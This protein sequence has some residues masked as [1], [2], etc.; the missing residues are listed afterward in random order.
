MLQTKEDF[1]NKETVGFAGS[2]THRREKGNGETIKGRETTSA[3]RYHWADTD[4]NGIIDDEEILA[5]YDDYKEI[6]GLTLGMEEIED[7][8]FGSGYKWDGVKKEFVVTY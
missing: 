7:I 3:S 4:K 8:W 6:D 5:V 1:N 2:I